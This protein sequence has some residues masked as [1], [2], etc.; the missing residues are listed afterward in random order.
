M[1]D[2]LK[3]WLV[4]QAGAEGELIRVEATPTTQNALIAEAESALVA[5]GYKPTEAAKAVAA[6]VSED[7][8]RSEELIR[9]ALRSMLPA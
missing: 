5:L 1:R 7:I 3:D 8:T 4:P 6:V 9:L 2:K